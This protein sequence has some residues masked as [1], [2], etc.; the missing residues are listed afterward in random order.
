MS[1]VKICSECFETRDDLRD[2]D[3]VLV[4]RVRDWVIGGHYRLGEYANDCGTPSPKGFNSSWDG[5][6]SA[7]YVCK[8]CA[9]LARDAFDE[10]SSARFDFQWE[11]ENDPTGQTQERFGR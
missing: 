4:G 3:E 6:E 11:L 9:C 8:S 5:S 7:H 1:E 2:L 10:C